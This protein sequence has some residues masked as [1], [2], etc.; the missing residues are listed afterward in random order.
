MPAQLRKT[1]L[2]LEETLKTFNIEASVTDVV[3]GPTITR[4]EL[5][6]APGIKVSRFHS[7]ADD[8]ALALKA[9]GVRVEAPIPGKGRVGIEV[10]NVRREPVV[11][12]ELFESKSFKKAKSALN[13][14][15][16][17]DIAG[18]V[19]QADLAT[20]PH[21]LVAGATGAG[22]TVCVKAFS[23]QS[24][25]HQHPRRDAAHPHR[26]QDGGAVDL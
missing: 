16:G 21:L 10:P 2:R 24:A 3:R 20:M 15:L 7:L 11:V 8:I 22:K 9:Q 19:M 26:S 5:Q 4:F 25:F 13:L 12:R 1:S 23:G 18:D 17:K 6:P 14:A